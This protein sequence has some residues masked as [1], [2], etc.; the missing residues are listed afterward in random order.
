MNHQLRQKIVQTLTYLGILSLSLSIGSD[1]V[2]AET[3]TKI[4][5]YTQDNT[6]ICGSK[7]GR[8]YRCQFD[9]PNGLD[10]V[11]VLSNASCQDKWLYDNRRKYIEVWDGCRARF[12]E[13]PYRDNYNSNN[14]NN[15]NTIVCGS[16]KG[17]PYR[18]SFDA[19][20][21]VEVMQ[22]LSNASCQDNWDYNQ[23]R[24]YIEVRNGC[25]AKFRARSSASN[26]F[27]FP[28]SSNNSRTVTCE[29]N[30][31]G[32]QRCRFDTRNGVSLTRQLS[33]TSCRGNW[34]YGNGFI[35]VK[36]GCRAEFSQE[37]SN[38]YF[39]EE[40]YDRGYRDAERGRRYD[41]YNNTEHYD[42]GYENGRRR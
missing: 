11:E 2:E 22:V 15:S 39:A 6:I 31:G 23:R 38:N 3:S 20:N 21:G 4:A 40:E 12:Q 13:S 5:Q 9:A 37:N 19:A 30:K 24:R 35:E 41:N 7:S 26:N 29:S 25:R 14:S 10:I 27:G 32:S 34:F 42:R 16:K 18:C 36:N 1:R 8:R 28:G 17:K 33:S